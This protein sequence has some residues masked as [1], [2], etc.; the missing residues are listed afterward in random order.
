MTKDV[1][2]AH[3]KLTGYGG[4]QHVAFEHARTFDAPIYTA[5]AD[6]EYIPDDVEVRQLWPDWHEHVR[7]LPTALMDAYHMLQW[8]HVKELTEYDTV[9]LN[10]T[11]CAWYVPTPDQTVI[12]YVHSPPRSTFD[13]WHQF[14]HGWISRIAAVAQRTIYEHTWNYPDAIVAN[15]ETVANRLDRYLDR[16][17]DAVVHPPVPVGEYSP[18]IA[19]T[20][21]VYLTLGRLAGNKNVPEI[22]QSAKRAGV[23]LLVAGDGPKR[24]DVER[25]ASAQTRVVGRVTEERKA[26][27]YSESS[28]FIMHASQE[29]FGLTPIEAMASGTPVIGVAEGHTTHQI[30]DGKNGILYDRENGGLYDAIRRFERDG[31]D[32]PPGKIAEYANQYSAERFREDMRVVVD[33]AQ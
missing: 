1:A 30:E 33:N 21:D 12:H 32:W 25:T 4:A 31:V 24:K 23:S 19:P 7:K 20:R 13:R 26:E 10:K 18:A 11:N 14:E 8:S 2:I 27:L 28:A 17:A 5:W 9:I 22:I 3:E 16:Q 15:S 6:D 29:D